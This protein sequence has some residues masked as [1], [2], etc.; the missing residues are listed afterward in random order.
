MEFVDDVNL[1]EYI[2]KN[3]DDFINDLVLLGFRKKYIENIYDSDM[4]LNQKIFNFENKLFAHLNKLDIN[5]MNFKQFLYKAGC[6]KEL[7][8]QYQDVTDEKKNFI[9]ETKKIY[10]LLLKK[11]NK[12]E[13]FFCLQKQI[14]KK[15]IDQK[16][17]KN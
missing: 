14:A 17:F 13:G 5:E 4:Y 7:A 16:I 1:M 15:K 12:F 9:E 11:N 10:E 8:L 3:Y 2:P 6:N